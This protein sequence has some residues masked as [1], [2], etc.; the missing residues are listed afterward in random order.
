MFVK[1]PL[2]K[3]MTKVCEQLLLEKQKVILKNQ[4]GKTSVSDVMRSMSNKTCP[5]ITCCPELD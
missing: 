4:T 3:E 5:G 2:N 1:Y